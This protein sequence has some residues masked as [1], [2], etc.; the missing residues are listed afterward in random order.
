MDELKPCPFCG[1]EAIISV[2]KYAVKDAKDRRWG[3]TIICSNCCAMSGHTYTVEKAR[4]AWNRRT[5][6]G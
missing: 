5:D 6:N 3:Y 2:D 1:G 4:E